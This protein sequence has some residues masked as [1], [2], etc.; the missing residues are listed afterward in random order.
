MTRSGNRIRGACSCRSER[1]NAV[2]GEA[3]PRTV[4]VT[5]PNE[6]GKRGGKPLCNVN[7]ERNNTMSKKIVRNLAF[8]LLLGVGG[9]YASNA[10]GTGTGLLGVTCS[11]TADPGCTCSCTAGGDSCG[12]AQACAN[13]K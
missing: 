5:S 4:A 3:F 6:R 10:Q 12:C 7:N 8:M 9:V 11:C 2:L 13:T 1:F